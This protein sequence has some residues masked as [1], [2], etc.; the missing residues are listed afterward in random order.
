MI[1]LYL[2][3]AIV[4]AIPFLLEATRAP[5]TDAARTQAPGQFA[6]LSQGVTHFQW[7]GT[8]DGPVA[9]CVHGLTTPG[10]VWQGI[11][12]GLAKMG[13]RVLVYDLYGRGYSDRPRGAQDR[14]FFQTQLTDLLQHEEIQGDITLIGYSM[15]GSIAAIFAASQP[16]RVHELI[17]L[18]PAGMAPVAQGIMGFAARTPIIGTWLMQA[19]YPSLLRKGLMAEAGNPSSVEGINALQ[20]AQLNWRG[21]VPA[22]RESLRGLLSEDLQAEHMALHH[23]EV[24][25]LA[26]WSEKD[27]IIPRSSAETLKRWNSDVHTAVIPGAGH[28]LPYSHT[29]ATL[30]HINAFTQDRR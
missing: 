26:I 2:I 23:H 14:R 3:L 18:A 27:D 1:W 16:A 24:P 17:L 6:R 30:E 8:G 20:V 22:V 19:R 29:G 11:A 21:F 9:V 13:F 28:G 10:F 7:Y 15:G 12:K 25:V 5:M 4:V